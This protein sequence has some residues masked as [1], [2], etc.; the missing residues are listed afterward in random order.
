MA[1]GALK[2]LC[3][4]SL[5]GFRGVSAGFLASVVLQSALYASDPAPPVTLPD[6][7]PDSPPCPGVTTSGKRT[8]AA[9]TRGKTIKF[10]KDVVSRIDEIIEKALSEC[11]VLRQKINDKSTTAVLKALCA[12]LGDGLEYHPPGGKKAADAAEGKSASKSGVSKDGKPPEPKRA[13][14]IASNRVLYARLDSFD[15]TSAKSLAEN[16]TSVFRQPRKPVGVILDLRNATAGDVSSAVAAVG[17][18]V[19]SGKLP[20]CGVQYQAKASNVPMVVLIDRGTKGPAEVF[21]SLAM[22]HGNVVTLGRSSAGRPFPKKDV[23]L[24]NGGT[25]SVPLIPKGLE[26]IP[27][28]PV[29]SSIKCDASPAVDYAELRG[30]IEAYKKDACLKRAVDLVICLEAISSR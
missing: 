15:K 19:S 27:R 5:R 8:S 22:A 9:T 28:T 21:T 17:L 26:E 3:F 1:Y 25:L 2:C 16:L 18:F 12:A 6:L 20:K 14:T 29:P 7:S 11:P 10:R 4:P 13:F 30:D 24:S 23:E